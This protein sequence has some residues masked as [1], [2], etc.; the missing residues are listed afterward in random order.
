MGTVSGKTTFS[1]ALLALLACG[2]SL[3]PPGYIDDAAFPKH[4]IVASRAYNSW[5]NWTRSPYFRI[6]DSI[7]LPIYLLIDQA[8][9]ACIV[10]DE[11]W[12]MQPRYAACPTA[13]RAR[14]GPTFKFR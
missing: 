13:W 11:I 3:L 14:R 4:R 5:Q 7:K 2:P 12:A 6:D 1:A 8:D 10:P 9:R